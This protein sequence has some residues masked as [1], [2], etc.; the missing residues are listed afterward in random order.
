M[1]IRIAGALA[2]LIVGFSCGSV[3]ESSSNESVPRSSPVQTGEMAPDFTLE[4]QNGQ[5]VTLSS[6]RG[7]APTVLVFY[8]GHW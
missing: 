2:I 7:T 3:K 5:K 6:S 8:R 4:D 1:R